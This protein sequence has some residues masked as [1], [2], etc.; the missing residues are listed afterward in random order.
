MVRKSVTQVQLVDGVRKLHQVDP[1][2]RRDV[3]YPQRNPLDG[4][5]PSWQNGYPFGSG[6]Q[7]K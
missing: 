5:R 4:V 7:V 1:N 2:T 6:F 3:D